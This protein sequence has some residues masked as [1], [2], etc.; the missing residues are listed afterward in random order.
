VYVAYAPNGTNELDEP[1][2]TESFNYSKTTL[3]YVRKFFNEMGVSGDP[4]G[5]AVIS[6]GDMGEKAIAGK[7]DAMRGYLPKREEA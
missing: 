4:A 5:F 6:Q 1:F 3:F 7:L 2:V